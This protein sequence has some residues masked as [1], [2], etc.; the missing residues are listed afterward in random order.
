MYVRVVQRSSCAVSIQ[1]RV[2]QRIDY[3]SRFYACNDPW[4][5]GQDSNWIRLGLAAASYHD[6]GGY[7]RFNILRWPDPAHLRRITER[8]EKP[9]VA[10]S[11]QATHVLKPTG[12]LVLRRIFPAAG[13]TGWF[14]RNWKFFEI[15]LK[16]R[17]PPPWS[18]GFRKEM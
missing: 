11:V 15:Y 13:F 18:A 17:F 1:T 8:S 2:I 5:L 16:P 6:R 3:A 7:I 10:V 14:G 4:K 9:T 12:D